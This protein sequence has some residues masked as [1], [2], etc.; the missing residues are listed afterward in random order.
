MTD[1]KISPFAESLLSSAPTQRKMQAAEK[2]LKKIQSQQQKQ[3][4]K[5]G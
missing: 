5:N 1:N 4:K 3:Q 2:E